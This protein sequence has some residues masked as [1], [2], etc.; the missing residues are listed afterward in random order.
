MGEKLILMWSR[1]QFSAKRKKRLHFS[2]GVGFGIGLGLGYDSGHWLGLWFGLW[3]GYGP[4]IRA[5]G[6]Q[7]RCHVTAHW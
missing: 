6:L 4:K 1:D 3:S 7:K 2:V 5:E